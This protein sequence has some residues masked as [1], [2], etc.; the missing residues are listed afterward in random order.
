MIVSD[1]WNAVLKSKSLHEI[2]TNRALVEARTRVNEEVERRTHVAPAFSQDG[3][4][5]LLRIH[6][7]YQVHPV[8]ATRWAGYL[9]AKNLQIVMVANDGYH[10]SGEH[11]NF[12]CRILSSLRR[13]PDEQRP[14]IIEIL[15]EYAA[16]ITDEGFFKRVGGDFATGHKEASGGIILTVSFNRI[17]ARMIADRCSE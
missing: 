13:L 9:R 11:T 15:K 6:S 4:V 1:A 16:R 3:R 8:I 12:S 10:P 17:V 14:N 7:A 5:A 2:S